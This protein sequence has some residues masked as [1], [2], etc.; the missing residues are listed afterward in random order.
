MLIKDIWKERVEHL[1]EVLFEYFNIMLDFSKGKLQRQC[2][3][4]SFVRNAC[5]IFVIFM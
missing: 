3:I 1:K 2:I 4:A 5:Y